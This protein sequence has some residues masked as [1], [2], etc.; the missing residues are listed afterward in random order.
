MRL[1]AC[2]L[3]VLVGGLIAPPRFMSAD[4]GGCPS[5][6]AG[7]VTNGVLVNGD[8]AM[9]WARAVC[10]TSEFREIE[11]CLRDAS[12][13][14]DVV[15]AAGAGHSLPSARMKWTDTP[16]VRAWDR[17]IVRIDGQEQVIT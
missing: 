11:V 2:A 14:I 9:L 7:V 5:V 3:V 15:C 4:P 6:H 8:E 16:P 10:V 1:L 13:G 17:I 12:A